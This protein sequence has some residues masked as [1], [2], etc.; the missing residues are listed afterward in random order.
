M[1]RIIELRSFMKH[2]TAFVILLAVYASSFAQTKKEWLKYADDAFSKGDYKNAVV[3]YTKV[4]D[5]NTP[6]DIT[7]PYETKPY[8]AQ[9]KD[10]A[11]SGFKI[12]NI[13]IAYTPSHG[14]KDSSIAVAQDTLKVLEV[15]NT[16]EQYVVHQIAES[17]R[18]NHDYQNA[19]L[20]YKQSVKN[21]LAE[22]PYETYL[23]GDALM[24]NMNYAA[25]NLQFEAALAT[26]TEKKNE[27][28][29]RL[30]KNKIAGCYMGVD[31]NSIQKGVTVTELDSVF[32]SG[33]ASFALGYYGDE[34]TLQFSSGRE[35]NVVADPKKQKAKYTSDLYIYS[36]TETGAA[37][38][39]K[40]EGPIN[41][42]QNEGMGYLSSDGGRFFF[43]RWLATNKKECA[44]YFSRYFNGEWL[45][46]QKMNDKVNLDGFRSTDPVITSDGSIIYYSSDRPGGYGKMDLWYEFIDQEGRTYGEPINMG[47]LFNTPEDEVSPFYHAGTST[48][49]F[50]SDG[51]S[52]YGGLDIFKASLN[53]DDS[54]W[55]APRNL[56]QPINSSKDD[57]YFI[58]DEGQQHGYFT[59]DRKEC[60]MC[61]GGACDKLY[62]VSKEKNVYDVKGTVYNSETN[63][64]V[65]NATITFKDIRSDWEPFSITT[66]TA[67]NYFYELKEGVELYMKAQKPNFLGD[68]GTVFTVGLTESK[69]FERDFFLSPISSGNI[70]FPNVEFDMETV[71]LRPSAMRVL[72]NLAEVL[73]LNNDFKISIESHTDIAERGLD[74][75]NIQLSEQRSK[76]CFDYLV[77]KGISSERMRIKGYGDTRL[78]IPKPLSEEEHQK[79]RRTTFN[80]VK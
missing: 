63:A 5:K 22:Y 45:I 64:V 3:Y 79:N 16:K 37:D 18:L 73:K 7:H 56:G 21:N 71:I 40:V 38:L 76:A 49:Y 39:K 23:L 60:E 67:G 68:A 12:F 53:K 59:S 35:G 27:A 26:A 57:K 9:K 30:A 4:I 75:H 17:Y 24:K 25:A 13:T 42:N 54:I 20:W 55:S 62:A 61:S 19:E 47:P 80:L 28:M 6:S 58:L 44:I 66:D 10:S 31:A 48:L 2:I 8:V 32:N 70:S 11:S 78:L 36:K 51:H 52:G 65:P 14:K 29:I 15:T 74:D 34:S 50:S 33:T 1:F 43:T 69:H 72:D 46:A 41:T 77:S